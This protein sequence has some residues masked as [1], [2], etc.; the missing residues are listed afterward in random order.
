ML[1]HLHRSTEDSSA[2]VRLA[3]PEAALEAVGPAADE[4]SRGDDLALVLLV[5]DDLGDLR[6]DILG[7]LGLTSDPGKGL[8]GVFD[9]ATLDKVSGRVG[10][11][12]QTTSEDDGP[13]ELEADG[14]LVGLHAV[15]VLGSVDDAGSEEETDGDAEL[16]TGDEGTANLLGA[17]IELLAWCCEGSVDESGL[18]ISDMYRI[19]MADSKPTPIPA[20]R[21]PTTMQARASP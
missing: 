11:E 13:R 1:H 20:M 2:E 7:V 4:R 17:L 5:G 3:I 18:T 15:E 6:L 16:V 12:E 14:D 10:E 8:D 21:R 9:A 19:T